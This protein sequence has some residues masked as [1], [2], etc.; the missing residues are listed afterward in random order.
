MSQTPEEPVDPRRSI[1]LTTKKNCGIAEHDDSFDLDLVVAINT[2]LAYLQ[3]L[4]VGPRNG[5]G[6]DGPLETWD[7]FMG[8]NPMFNPVKSYVHLR[9][10]MIFDPPSTSYHIGAIR[11]EIREL[12]ARLI[13]YG[14]EQGMIVD[15][16]VVINPVIVDEDP[17]DG[18]VDGQS[19]DVIYQNAKV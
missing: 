6:I 10:R 8:P 19:F 4:G 14:E 12:E 1:L 15:D 2:V 16:V 5:F 18:F 17:D 3:Q 11:E 7:E 9:V 13:M